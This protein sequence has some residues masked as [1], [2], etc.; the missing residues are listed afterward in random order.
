MYSLPSHL[1]Q[2]CQEFLS[3][4]LPILQADQRLWGVA[5]GGSLIDGQMDEYSDLDLVIAV[6]PMVYQQVLAE[7]QTIAQA[8]GPYLQGFIGD[9]VGEPRLLIC[10]YGPPLFHVDLKF[11][12]AQDLAQR[13][14]DPVIFWE[15][16]QCM[17]KAFA[18]QAAHFPPPDLQW[19]ED[20][21]WVWLHYG[22][23]R[24]GRGELFEALGL[25]AFLRDRVLGPMV[26][27]KHQHPPRGVRR[28][29]WHA[30]DD[31]PHLLA[32][33]GT[34]DAWT[35]AQALQACSTLYQRL[36]SALA[37]QDL[38]RH[39]DAEQ[40]AQAYLEQLLARL[41]PAAPDVADSSAK[42]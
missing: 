27:L 17:T 8:L 40:A 16:H 38:K 4:A 33:I 19:I 29:E 20:R 15:R 32:T 18:Q 12:S 7:R 3:T 37:P 10:L 6:D 36:R 5:G 35:C 21:F 9:H 13:V 24:I 30:P 11:V 42:L 2:Q 14:E 34:Y 31:L 22:A 41:S 25:L 1:P 23:A 28:L 39:T 26:L